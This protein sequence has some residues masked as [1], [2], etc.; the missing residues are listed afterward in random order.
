M[1][2]FFEVSFGIIYLSLFS[3]KL[4]NNDIM[5]TNNVYLMIEK[6]GL[7]SNDAAILNMA[8][9]SSICGFVSNDGDMIFTINQGTYNP[10]KFFGIQ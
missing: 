6:Y 8:N 5:L 9:Y 1:V 10:A 3:F 7:G 4:F 2:M